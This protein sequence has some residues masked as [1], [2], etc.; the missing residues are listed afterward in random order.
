MSGILNQA[1]KIYNKDY[2]WYQWD[3]SCY[4][5]CDSRMFF[6][7]LQTI[8]L[9]VDSEFVITTLYPN[10]HYSLTIQ[11]NHIVYKALYNI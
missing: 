1:Y 5:K 6:N 8:I 3:D 2:V 7:L 11:P 4:S 10:S 9:M